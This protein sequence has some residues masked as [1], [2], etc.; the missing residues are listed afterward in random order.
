MLVGGTKGSGVSGC[1][2]TYHGSKVNTTKRQSTE[3]EKIFAN[4]ATD[5]QNIQTTH[6]TQL[7]KIKN[8]TTQFKNRQKTSID[9]SP[10]K[11]YGQT[12]GI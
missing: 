5:I 10:K 2:R 3:W 8:R 11:T 12:T 6:A 4:N 9:I 7:Q 1:E